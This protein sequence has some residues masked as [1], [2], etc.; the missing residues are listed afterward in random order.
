MPAL[1]RTL[2]ALFITLVAFAA[3]GAATAL[4]GPLDLDPSFGTGGIVTTGDAHGGRWSA[5]HA[6]ADGTFLAAGEVGNDQVA[7]ARF[8][9]T[10]ALDASFAAD[11]PVPGILAFGG[12]QGAVTPKSLI[13]LADGHILVAATALTAGG[14]EPGIIVARL[15]AAGHLDTGFGS[16]G[17]AV[18]TTSAGGVTLGHIA[19]QSTGAIIVVG[20]HQITTNS[21]VLARLT[22]GGAADTSFAGGGQV[23]VLLGTSGVRLDDVAIDG[24]DRIVATGWRTTGSPTKGQLA[25][26]RYS[27]GGAIDLTYGTG[28]SGYVVTDLDGAS[29][30]TYDVEGKRL[31]LSADGHATVAARVTGAG[32]NH[33]LG[34]ARFTPNG[35]L[36]SSFGTGA[37][38]TMTQDTSPSH[39]SDVEDFAVA[40][41]GS[42]TLA[43]RMT[44][45]TT[46]QVALAQYHADG[47]PDTSAN[48][49]HAPTANAANITISDGGD[50]EAYAVALAPDTGRAILGGR[51]ANEARDTGF[52]ARVGGT[53]SAPNASFTTNYVQARA[54][55][56]VRPGQV[57]SFDASASVDAD[58]TITAYAWDF[59]GDGQTDATGP[60]AN[61]SYNNVGAHGVLLKVT[62]DDQLTGT[63]GATVTVKANSPPG[64][65]I[66]EPPAVP[67]AGK[68]FTL[69]A[70]AGDADGSVV[71]YAWD[72]DGNGTYET[73]TGAD[74][75]VKA[76]YDTAGQ[77]LLGLRVTDDEGTT[78]S[79]L[80]NLKVGEGPCIENPIVKIEQAVIVT[81]G[82]AQAGAGCFHAVTVD[83]DGIRTVTYTTDGHFRVNGLEVD[84][85]LTSKAVLIWKRKLVQV[86]NK[87]TVAPGD[88]VSATLTAANV[89]VVGTYKNTDFA[90]IDGK[91]AWDLAGATI[92]GF[93][94]DANAG[95]G[96]LPLKVSG[97][98]KLDANG[99]STLDILPGTPPEL[100]GKTP[101][102]P[103]HAV[104]GPSATTAALTPFS[105][106][107][108]EIPLGVI[109]LGPV[110]IT[111]SGNGNW[112]ISAK[113]SMAVPVPTTLEGEL[114]L[115]H[116]KVKMVNLQFEGTI[117]VGPLF[118]THVGLTIDFGPK[119]TANKDCIKHVG[120][121]DITPYE[122]W[123]F[124]DKLLPG[125]KEHVLSQGG[126][127]QILFHQLF[128]DY[129]TPTFALCGSIGLSVAKL[130]E[131][132]FGF[133]FGRYPSPLPNVLFFHGEGRVVEIIKATIDAEITTEGYVHVGAAVK[134]GYPDDDPWIGWELGLDFEYFKQQFNAEAYAAITIVPL[135]FTA[136]ARLLASNKGIVG[137]L[138]IDTVFGDWHPG[139]G[140]KWGHGPK[141]YFFGCDVNDYKVV[142]QHAL[143]GDLVIGPPLHGMTGAHAAARRSVRTLPQT[144]RGNEA[145]IVRYTGRSA[146]R[147]RAAQAAPD[148]IDIPAGLPGTVMAFKGA[149]APPHV[150]LHGPK[151]ETIDSGAGNAPVHTPGVA[152][153]KNAREGITEV[154]IAKPASGRWT[155]ELASDSV[156]LV[157]A[158][159]AD[160]TRP[161]KITGKVGGSGQNRTFTYTVDGLG[162]G[163]RIDFAEVG[164]A[165]GSIIGRVTRDGSG[166]LAFHPGQGAAGKR[167]VQAIVTNIDGFTAE[168]RKLGTYT[169]PNPPRPAA[170]RK[171]TLRRSGKAL[172][173]SWPR[174]TLAKTT[175]IDVRTSN[176]LNVTR[177]VKGSRLRLAAPPAGTTL[178]VTLTGTSRSGVLGRAAHFTRR[179]AAAK[180]KSHKAKIRKAKAHQQKQAIQHR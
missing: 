40:P 70:F 147:A 168:R 34:L 156:R 136:G 26:T 163:Q 66:I 41:D 96:G 79:A 119:V 148:A 51:V 85:L 47:T 20:T 166:T 50:A 58:G 142:I 76:K 21:G 63:T 72:L 145:T 11:Q 68:A 154:V 77:H 16:G 36:D 126:P 31:R 143:S 110:K 178:K 160:G 56:P 121:E 53:A 117:T 13:V 123:D 59:D 74:P 130:V 175:Q 179:L 105:Y 28:A 29:A 91:I 88:T 132:R 118:I 22:A 162:K 165:A 65:A 60:T 39:I 125:Y 3:T 138:T 71:S 73:S 82:T 32:A 30:S 137:C 61:T 101:S 44:V 103:M 33:L 38:G 113:A 90:F 111:Y 87:G 55:R 124:L 108:D 116:G 54:G 10:G 93:K 89:K 109:T 139:G 153:L 170:A 12:G 144:G 151:G 171:L 57:V 43:G 129:K 15:T 180:T 75:K 81:Q 45:G 146:V 84:T 115:A 107:V 167:D 2:P 62:D 19:L 80:D 52:V 155:V 97:T 1:R 49:G 140:A 92:G 133:G 98:P 25:I 27:P 102:T 67:Q 164:V 134:G 95:I 46:Q 64:A 114:A 99:T 135:D 127:N 158:L 176:G 94:V 174:N 120:L 17:V 157:E 14:I 7:V 173:L 6:N 83:K 23:R 159:Q 172:I 177:I 131:A 78:G 37:G 8:S 149:G 24:S 128:K 169:A 48:P 42:L 141:L 86:P 150:I 18:V 112:D 69:T 122:T 9:A 161:A 106:T 35:A 104:F 4:A 100:L 152:A 5:L